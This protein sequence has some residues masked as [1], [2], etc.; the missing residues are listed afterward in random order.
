MSETEKSL[1]NCTSEQLE[2][3]LARLSTDQIRYVVARQEFATDK[4]AAEEIGISPRT[5]YS[6][7]NDVREAVRMM[8][9][10]GLVTAQHIR[11]RNLAKAMLIKVKGLDSDD[12][13]LRQ[14]VATEIIEWE[15]GK[16]KQTQEMIGDTALTVS[17]HWT[18]D[19]ISEN[20]QGLRQN[21]ADE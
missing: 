15:M 21:A 7:G 12:D 20:V 6:W 18:D 8:A 17:L 9:L 2:A 10:D 14:K 13:V 19:V 11:R 1:R 3:I 16:A 4:E 5:V